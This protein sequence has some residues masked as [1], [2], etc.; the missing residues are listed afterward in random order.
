MRRARA[1]LICFIMAGGLACATA[2]TALAAPQ[3]KPYDDKLLR[4]SEILGAIHYLRELCG[5]NEGQYWR[6]RM[7]ELMEA[8]GSSTLRRARLTRAFNQGYRSY[9]RTYNTCSP[10]AQ[11]AVTRF[12]TEG[13]ELSEGLIKS[14]PQ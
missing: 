2:H 9:S 8:E 13:A 3:A 1:A 5:A 7:R 11:T 14:F 6:D 4:L 12:I 10:S